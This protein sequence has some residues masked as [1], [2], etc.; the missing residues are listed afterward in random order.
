MK[1]VKSVVFGDVYTSAY[2][3][4]VGRIGYQVWECACHAVDGK[5]VMLV[6][7]VKEAIRLQITRPR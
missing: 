7:P 1:P 4:W 2:W 5:L 6:F 3:F